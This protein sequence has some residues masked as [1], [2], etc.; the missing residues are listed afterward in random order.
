MLFTLTLNIVGYR[1]VFF[2]RQQEIKA[3]MRNL[4][5]SMAN[6]QTDI[7]AILFYKE[8]ELKNVKWEDDGKEFE[9]NDEMYDVIE[10]RTEN[11]KIII[12]CIGDK[13]ETALIKKFEKL[14]DEAR[15]SAQSKSNTIEKLLF[16]SFFASD[17]SYL[18]VVDNQ[19]SPQFVYPPSFIS[20]I[21][22]EVLTPP[23]QLS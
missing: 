20:S 22:R 7:P 13:N 21:N 14:R 19:S 4:I 1:V 9:L 16:S 2:F 18:F 10:K 8:E 11:G 5:R 15:G 23:P 17:L 3:E 12:V 6:H